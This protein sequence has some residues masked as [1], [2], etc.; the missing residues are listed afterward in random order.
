MSSVNKVLLLGN[1]TA[2]PDVRGLPSGQQVCNLRLAVNREYLSSS[3]QPVTETCY[4]DVSVFGRT[5][6]TCKQFLYKGAAVFIEGR[7]HLEQ[8]TDRDGQ[9]KQ[10]LKV[11]SENIQ[12]C[13][14]PR[15]ERNPPRRPE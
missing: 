1:L 9:Q 7:L 6:T 12:F 2:E 5:A 11:I 13:D 8:W 14:Q 4:V 15:F 3:G 10:K